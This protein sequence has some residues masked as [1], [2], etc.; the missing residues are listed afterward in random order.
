MEDPTRY[1]PRLNLLVSR[2]SGLH[3]VLCERNVLLTGWSIIIPPDVAGIPM[4]CDQSVDHSHGVT[5]GE[6]LEIGSERKYPVVV[7]ADV[8]QDT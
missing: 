5:E 6:I 4:L 8:C 1:P 3:H 2:L 7:T